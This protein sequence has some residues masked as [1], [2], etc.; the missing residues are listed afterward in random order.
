MNV[1]PPT[2]LVSIGGQQLTSDITQDIISFVFE[3]N[4]EEADLKS[5]QGLIV[6]RST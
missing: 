4:E 1:W 5:H 3:D 6:V 2:F